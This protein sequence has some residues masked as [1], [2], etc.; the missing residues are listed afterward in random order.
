MKVHFAE[1]AFE[2]ANTMTKLFGY[3]YKTLVYDYTRVNSEGKT[4]T[5]QHNYDL[6]NDFPS[7]FYYSGYV[8]FAIYM[9]F[10]A[11]F[12]GLIIV[13]VI[14]K[15]KK[16]VNLENGLL[17]ITFALALGCSQFSGNVLRRPN[18]S[19]Y[20]SVILAYIYY[21]TVVRENVRFRDLFS[22]FKRKKKS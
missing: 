11:Y 15:F 16:C 9:L 17:A 18:A 2:D 22:I 6:E 3:E 7:V 19:I 4:V 21:V 20:M 10:I 14:T 13:A 8:G 5:T 12:V 1:M